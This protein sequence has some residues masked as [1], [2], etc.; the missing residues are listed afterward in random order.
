[1]MKLEIYNEVICAPFLR[2]EKFKDFKT[3]VDWRGRYGGGFYSNGQ[4]I[5]VGQEW[6]GEEVVIV[7]APSHPPEVLQRSKSKLIFGG[8]VYSE[9]GHFLLETLSRLWARKFIDAVDFVFINHSLNV[10]LSANQIKLLEC[11]GPFAVVDKDPISTDFLI[12]PHPSL[13][14][15]KYINPAAYSILREFISN[16]LTISNSYAGKKVYISRLNVNK[17]KNLNEEEVS[18]YF[19]CKGF[20][21]IIPENLSI[22][23][24]IDIFKNSSIIVSA[25]GSAWHTLILTESLAQRIYLC[26]EGYFFDYKLVES[27]LSHGNSFFINCMVQ[28]TN[29]LE[30]AYSSDY[31]IDISV[32]DNFLRDIC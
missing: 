11:F 9:W 4:F 30:H 1:M 12:H 24:Q 26:F 2:S 7:D 8:Y 29:P 27:S 19:K 14:M 10:G 5:K 23:E 16:K 28:S 15:G 3:G 17:R 22:E 25:I 18:S 32:V 21:I 6:Y 20:E 31:I 13:Q